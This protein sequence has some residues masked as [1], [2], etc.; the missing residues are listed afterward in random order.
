M[1]LYVARIVR[2]YVLLSYMLAL[3]MLPV[4]RRRKETK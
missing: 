4:P 2:Q 1:S 3:N